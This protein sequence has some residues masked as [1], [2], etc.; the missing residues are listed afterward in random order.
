MTE[1]LCPGDTFHV[2]VTVNSSTYNLRA[3][4]MDLV[5]NSTVLQVNEITVS[6]PF[7]S[8]LTEP[9][10]GDDGAGTIH[11]GIANTEGTYRPSAGTFIT[12]EFEVKA[13][14]ADGNYAL[15]LQN[16]VLKDEN[17]DVIPGVTVTDGEGVVEC[18]AISPT[19]TANETA[20]A[21]AT[22]T[23]TPT[24]NETANATATP[25]ANATATATETTTAT[26]TLTEIPTTTA[27]A[28]E[29]PAET[30]ESTE[31]PVQ[32]GFG[33]ALLLIGL[34][35]VYILKRKN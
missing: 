28:T 3:V 35:A 26:A 10:S 30:P 17:N 8:Y 21:T 20:N 29:T 19:A 14:A 22:V 18:N 31:T 4:S 7:T 13:G 6:G 32:P 9:G 34:A 23:A 25:T 11:Y 2:T 27:T 16:V 15:A 5:Y 33:I 24:A 12:V 1:N